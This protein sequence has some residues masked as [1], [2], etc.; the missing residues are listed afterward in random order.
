M[1]S[2]LI[3]NEVSSCGSSIMKRKLTLCIPAA[4]ILVFFGVR[5]APS[6]SRPGTA[7][8]AFEAASIKTNRSVDGSWRAGCGDGRVRTVP[9]GRCQATNV[10]LLRLIATAY[11]LPVFTAGEY[12]S[13]IPGS[14]INERYDLDAKAENPAASD[15][16]LLLM[17][18][19]LLADRFKLRLH[20]ESK[21][22]NG[23]ALVVAK[24]GPKLRRLEERKRD[25][26]VAV[27]IGATTTTGLVNALSNRLQAPVLDRTNIQGDYDFMVTMDA[28]SGDGAPSIFTLIEEQF[29][30]KLESQ[31]VPLKVLVVDHVEKPTEN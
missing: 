20:E 4:S 1:N 2:F 5:G 25:K 14:L 24:G 30:L 16:E 28:L 8:V 17:L 11:A 3:Q 9:A 12:V 13:G 29:G 27:A 21:E 15:V 19:N 7:P 18:Q 23:Y 6:Q 26:P 10:S 31:K 22:V